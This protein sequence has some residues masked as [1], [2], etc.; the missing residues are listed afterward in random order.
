MSAGDNAPDA[1]GERGSL[2]GIRIA[3]VSPIAPARLANAE[4]W[5][6]APQ[7]DIMPSARRQRP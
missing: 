7:D 2:S 6:F 1:P 3:A 5:H 4:E